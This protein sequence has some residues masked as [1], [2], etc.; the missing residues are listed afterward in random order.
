MTGTSAF[1]RWLIDEF[2]KEQGIDLSQDRQALQRLREA[3][4]K[5]GELSSRRLEQNQPALVRP[6]ALNFGS[7]L[8]PEP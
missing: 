7:S 2:K 8:E 4:E 1:L 3:A 6:I 5:A